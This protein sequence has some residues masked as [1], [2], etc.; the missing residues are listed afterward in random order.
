MVWSK[1]FSAG[2]PGGMGRDKSVFPNSVSWDGRNDKGQ[3]VGNGGY[4]LIAKGVA[5]GRTI[6]DAH[7]KIAVVR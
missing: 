5:N 7:R 3:K 1:R 4:I 2:S 6:M